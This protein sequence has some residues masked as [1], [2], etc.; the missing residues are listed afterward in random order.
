MVNIAAANSTPS[1][2]V[3]SSVARPPERVPSERKEAI[4]SAVERQDIERTASQRQNK[5]D[6]Q[7]IV[8][9]RREARQASVE[10][11]GEQVDI[12]V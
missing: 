3:A 8:N 7:A 12:L 1:P 5:A 2:Q 4:D 10:Q 11:A 6:E 9:N